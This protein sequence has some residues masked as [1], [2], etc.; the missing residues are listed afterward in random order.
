MGRHQERPLPRK[1]SGPI[2]FSPTMGSSPALDDTET[3]A[4]LRSGPGVAPLL[5]SSIPRYGEPAVNLE[6]SV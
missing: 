4:D 5:T 1:P 3:Y 2:A 6:Q